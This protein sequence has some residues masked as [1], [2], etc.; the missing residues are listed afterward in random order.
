MS[1]RGLVSRKFQN[2]GHSGGRNFYKFPGKVQD[3]FFLDILDMLKKSGKAAA[4]TLW[5]AR[6]LRVKIE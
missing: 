4:G 2:G 1:Q 6:D 3:I 5:S